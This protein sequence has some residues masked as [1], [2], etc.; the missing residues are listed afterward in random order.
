[1]Q[2]I[3]TPVLDDVRDLRAIV[4]AMRAEAAQLRA[5]ND[6]L[7]TRIA[8]LMRRVRLNCAEGGAQ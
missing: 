6:Q 8:Q 3:Y 5:E 1:M 7:N 4:D 2:D